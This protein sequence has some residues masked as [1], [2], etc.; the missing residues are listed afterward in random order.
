MGV[1][2]EAGRETDAG[3]AL[4]LLLNDVRQCERHEPREPRPTSSTL[5]E[6][7]EATAFLL[8]DA[9]CR[10]SQGG[11]HDEPSRVSWGFVGQYNAIKKMA[12]GFL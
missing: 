2:Y 7:Q 11:C 4:N 5:G 1:T 12:R 8:V 3:E 10:R 6:A 9:L